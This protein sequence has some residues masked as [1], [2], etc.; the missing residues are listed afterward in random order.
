MGED[1]RRRWLRSRAKSTIATRS[2]VSRVIWERSG[3]TWRSKQSR[4]PAE[5]ANFE[6]IKHCVGRGRDPQA[7][8]YPKTFRSS[9]AIGS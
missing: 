4:A 3:G 6:P 7:F 8:A 9:I 5:A 2:L 1:T